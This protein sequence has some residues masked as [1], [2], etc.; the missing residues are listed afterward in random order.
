MSFGIPY[1]SDEALV[2]VVSFLEFMT[3]HDAK[4]SALSSSLE[5]PCCYVTTITALYQTVSSLVLFIALAKEMA[6]ALFITA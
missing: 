1:F 5:S 2:K 4:L 6:V 3:H